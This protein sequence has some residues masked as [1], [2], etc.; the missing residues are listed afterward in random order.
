MVLFGSM[1]PPGKPLT[2][3]ELSALEH[4][5]ASDPTSDA[6]RPLTEAYLT[7]GRFMEAM[8]VCKKGVKAHPDDPSARVLLARVYAD[9]GK[10]RKALEELGGVLAA[11]PT[12][13]AANK[14]AAVLHFRLGEREP[15][16]AA[17]R[18]AAE[19]ASE[20]AEIRELAT[21]HGV[22]LFPPRAA[23]SPRVQTA[24]SVAAAATEPVERSV[25]VPIPTPVPSRR[26]QGAAYAQALAEKYGTQEFALATGAKPKKKSHRAMLLG[27]LGLLVILVGVAVGFFVHTRSSGERAR[28]IDGLLKE[29]REQLDKDVY[30]AYLAAASKATAILEQDPDSTA[31]HA[32]LAYVDALR[33]AEHGDEDAVRQEALR[34]LELG[35]RDGRTHSH[36]VAAEAWLKVGAGDLTGARDRLQ[37]VLS[38]EGTQQS[39]FLSAILGAVQLRLGDLDAARDTLAAAQKANPGDVRTAWLLAE[40]YRR[41]GVGYELQASSY[42]DYALKIQKDHLPSILGKALVLLGRGQLEDAAK[43]AEVALAPQTGASKPQLALAHAIKGGVLAARGKP[44]AATAEEALASKL[45]PNNADLPWLVGVRKLRA[46]DAAGAVDALQKAVSLDPKRVSLYAD[47]TRALLQKDGGA[48][49]AVDTLKR[50]VTRLGE[51][52]RLSLAL[53]DAYLAAGDLDL[54]RGNYEKAIQLGHPY[55]D[56]RVALARLYRSQNNIPGA[57]VELTSAI[58]EY[59]AGGT[60]GVAAAYVE[61]AEAE[62]ARNARPEKLRELYAKAL[63]KDAVSCDALWG[64]ARATAEILRAGGGDRGKL[65]TEQA[66]LATNYVRNCPSGAHVAE[67]EKL[68]GG[69]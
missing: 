27:S 16:E 5:F 31:G 9:Q 25:D 43:A 17:L 4:A 18:R 56:A 15:A 47:L 50:A 54:A 59:G 20:D 60:G 53:G 65:A 52:P 30:P 45:D 51:H 3:A 69:K 28:V 55:P 57:L 13:A 39:P 7:A 14:L 62:R 34:Q 66:A 22:A 35:A 29:I 8:V 36:L 24:A 38:A 68:A 58:D 26:A 41:R 32:Y 2:P 19:A 10:D 44:D 33:W 23:A 11:F 46:G 61:M 37:G 48:K 21:K 1:A 67:A 49:Q 63:E 6:Y 64:G 42:Y 40:Q 12:F